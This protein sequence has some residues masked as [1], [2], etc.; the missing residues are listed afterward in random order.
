MNLAEFEGCLDG[1]AAF[2]FITTDMI[3]KA[4]AEAPRLLAAMQANPQYPAIDIKHERAMQKGSVVAK[5]MVCQNGGPGAA[6]PVLDE[7]EDDLPVNARSLRSG[8]SAI[9]KKAYA[10]MA[11]WREPSGSSQAAL[12]RYEAFPHSARCVRMICLCP[13][14][15]AASERVFS[16]LK[17][18]LT[19]QQFRKLMDGLETGLMLRY[20]DRDT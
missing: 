9:N 7:P 16:L 1:L 13:P 10:C 4:K 14:S 18:A 12:P 8:Q 17:L 15:S 5:K 19:K 11:W 20:N 2:D 3:R 6:R